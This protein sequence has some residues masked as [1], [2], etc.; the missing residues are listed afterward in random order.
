MEITTDR[1]GTVFLL[2][3]WLLLLLL[4]M[5]VLVAFVAWLTI[6][7]NISIAFVF[8]FLFFAHLRIDLFF[9]IVVV[10]LVCGHG[11]GGRLVGV[12]EGLW[13]VGGW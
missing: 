13:L 3:S 2:M 12:D 7:V 11:R 6:A 8:F 4:M 5:M 1:C 10:F 9:G